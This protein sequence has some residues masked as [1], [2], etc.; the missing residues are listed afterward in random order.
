MTAI[1]LYLLRFLETK[2][3]KYTYLDI[4]KPG[5]VH[6]LQIITIQSRGTRELESTA[7]FPLMKDKSLDNTSGEIIT[8]IMNE[9]TSSKLDNK[10]KNQN[11]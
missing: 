4:Y 11:S 5:M 3:P 10:K 6:T 8:S 1:C 2:F 7:N 9:Q